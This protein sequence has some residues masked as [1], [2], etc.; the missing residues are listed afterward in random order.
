M[1]FSL[2]GRE[3]ARALEI[4]QRMGEVKAAQRENKGEP[5]GVP[6]SFQQGVLVRNP[7]VARKISHNTSK[8]TILEIYIGP[9]IVLN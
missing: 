7:T 5:H 3:G 2:S 8:I 1:V 6:S 4:G 9:R